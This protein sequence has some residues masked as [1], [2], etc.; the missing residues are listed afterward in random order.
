MS[1][2][3]QS[4][5]VR[6]DGRTVSYGIYWSALT[7]SIRGQYFSNFPYSWILLVCNLT[8]LLHVFEC[9]ECWK[10]LSDVQHVCLSHCDPDVNKGV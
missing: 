4:Q 6:P 8:I 1:T 2:D 3:G 10:T 7:T 9:H 5:G